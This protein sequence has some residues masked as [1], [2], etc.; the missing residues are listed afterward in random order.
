MAL[1][2]SGTWD[3]VHDG[4]RGTLAQYPA[5]QQHVSVDGPCRFSSSV[6]SG[7]YTDSQGRR[8]DV[9]GSFGVKDEARRT[10]EQCKQSDH[11]VRFTVAFP[12]EPPQEF[13]GY[14]FTRQSGMMAGFTWWRGTPFGWY[15]SRR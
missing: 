5:D 11:L 3:M 2:M 15:A 14:L 12:G 6:I 13:T 7:T 1:Q 4:W 10:H 9:R 8:Y